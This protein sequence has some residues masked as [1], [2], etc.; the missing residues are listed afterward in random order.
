VDLI[1]EFLIRFLWDRNQLGENEVPCLY[2]D[3]RAYL[4]QSASYTVGD[5]RIGFLLVL[6]LLPEK[7]ALAPH[8]SQ[9]LEVVEVLDSDGQP[10]HIA[11]ITVSCSRTMPS[12]M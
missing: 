2:T 10:R 8:L 9:C 5:Q 3:K 4:G 7:R 11:A 12:S 6:K 1:S